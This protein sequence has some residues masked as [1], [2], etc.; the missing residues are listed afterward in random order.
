M[1]QLD[2]VKGLDEIVTHAG[3]D[4]EP[5]EMS[6]Q[7]NEVFDNSIIEN[8]D[9]ELVAEVESVM[10]AAKSSS[11]HSMRTPD[12]SCEKMSPKNSSRA[13]QMSQDDEMPFPD[14]DDDEEV[15]SIPISKRNR[16]RQAIEEESSVKKKSKR[17]RKIHLEDDED[18]EVPDVPIKKR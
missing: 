18:E 7:E 2:I 15:P 5:N 13:K 1:H 10:E 8:A 11:R 14:D 16:R 3:D 9:P 12:K 17:T 6:A 4:M